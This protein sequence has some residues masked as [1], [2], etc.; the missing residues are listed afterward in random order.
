MRQLW[1]CICHYIMSCAPASAAPHRTI[2]QAQT[3]QSAIPAQSTPLAASM[4]SAADQWKAT[5]PLFLPP[6]PP[7]NPSPLPSIVFGSLVTGLKKTITGLD[8]D[9]GPV[10]FG[11]SLLILRNKKPRTGFN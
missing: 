3:L 11:H 6:N 4:Q 10:F 1:H 5:P 9:C 7:P 2:T 8:C